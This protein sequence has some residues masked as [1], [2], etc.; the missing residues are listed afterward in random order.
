MLLWHKLRRIV[1]LIFSLVWI[2]GCETYDPKPLDLESYSQLWHKRTLVSEDLAQFVKGLNT[3]HLINKANFDPEDGLT[4]IEGEL[5]ALVFNPDLRMA[6]QHAK[7]TEA[8]IPYVGL[9]KDPVFN[10]NILN[11]AERIPDPWYIS[12]SLSLTIPIS[13]RKRAEKTLAAEEVKAEEVPEE[14]A[15]EDYYY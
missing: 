7:V 9:W 11:I 14:D 13:G 6:R 3:T 4:L 1:T 10:L 12:S 2:A 15:A 5:V 8:K